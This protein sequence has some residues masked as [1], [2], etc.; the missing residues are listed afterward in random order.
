MSKNK[1]DFQKL[2]EEK[3]YSLI[4][5]IIDKFA[6]DK[7]NS[8]L[9]NLSGATKMQLSHSN[10]SLE[11]AIKDFRKAYLKEK[12]STNAYHGLKNFVNASMILFDNKFPNNEPEL[13]QEIFGEIIR[14]Y[15]ENKEFFEK[16]FSNATSIIR[17]FKK[18]FH[19]NF[20]DTS[21]KNF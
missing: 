13:E 5:S 6:E 1:V 10:E 4:L 8:G 18:N 12:N 19:K 3:K 2:F 21:N 14:Y 9:Y 17:V 11:S 16:D 20:L 15:N 7:K